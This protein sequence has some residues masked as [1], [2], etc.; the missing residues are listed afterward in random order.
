MYCENCGNKNES[1]VKFCSKCGTSI[2][3]ENAK[4]GIG[5][6]PKDSHL[7]EIISEK[8]HKRL[9]FG[10]LLVTI[11]FLIFFAE[12][13]YISN[14]L[15]GP[16]LKTP[17]AIEQ[18]LVAGNP[19]DINV[20]LQLNPSAVYQSGYTHITQSVNSSTNQVESETT[21]SEYYL[22]IIGK[23]ILV[24]EGKPN[25]KPS[26]NFIGAVIPIPQ[27]L[28]SSI[29]AE[30]NKTPELVG[31][32]KYILP[33]AISDKGIFNLDN[34][35]TL[36]IG[37]ALFVWGG[38]LTF[39]RLGDIDDKNHYAYGLITV[40]GYKNID[41]FSKDFVAAKDAGILSIGNFS[42]SNKFLYNEGFFSFSIYPMSQM[43]WA[44][45]QVV[46]KSVN[47]IPTGKDYKVVMNFRPKTSVEIKE[48]E[49]DVN[50]HLYLLT[51]LYPWAKF[52]YE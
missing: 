20:N 9:Y 22:T 24:L 50:K 41:D 27:D 44:Y 46:R 49:E 37:V 30:F 38:I 39:K 43:F 4:K 2:A 8:S 21:D 11:S 42:L 12:R 29:S 6:S 15:S 32:D 28:E 1:G 40:L 18:E 25:Q 17:E 14:I 33:Y 3:T 47:L 35:W 51:K 13:N 34:I 52:G 19:K 45:K 5:K 16:R 48:S 26:S 23:H 10:I 7:P 31:L 36:L